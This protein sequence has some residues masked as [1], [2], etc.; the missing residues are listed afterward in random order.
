MATNSL[1]VAWL[2]SSVSPSIACSVHTITSAAE[3]WKILSKLYS[4][5]GNVMMLAEIDD[6]ISSL[7]QG[8]MFV[9]DYVAELNHLWADLDHYDPINLR[10]IECVTWVKKWIEKGRV[11]QFLRGLNSDF[12]G[13]RAAM[14]YQPTLPSLE[15]AISAIAQ[16]ETRQKL[17][18]ENEL[19]P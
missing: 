6:K 16:E 9:M 1:V 12:E 11:L 8:E 19:P 17:K 3:V 18:K 2:L 5:A 4:G 7:R 15:E 13:R 10:H 14:F